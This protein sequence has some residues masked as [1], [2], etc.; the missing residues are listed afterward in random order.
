MV[1]NSS[2]SCA[3]SVNLVGVMARACKKSDGRCSDDTTV[4]SV[5][6]VKAH[7]NSVHM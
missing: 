5:N 1:S 2:S 3:G 4:L 6:Q 7:S